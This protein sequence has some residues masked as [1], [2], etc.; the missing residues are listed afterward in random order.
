MKNYI[1]STSS[2]PPLD[3]IL[4][5]STEPLTDLLAITKKCLDNNFVS[6]FLAIIGCVIAFHYEAIMNIQDE[7]PLIL[8][9]SRES[10][11]GIT[12]KIMQK[13]I[14]Q[15]ICDCVVLEFLTQYIIHFLIIIGKSTSLKNALSLFGAHLNN[16][17]APNTPLAAIV[18]QASMTTVP[19][20]KQCTNCH[21]TVDP[22]LSEPQLSD[23]AVVRW[24]VSSTTTT[25]NTST[26][27]TTGSI[28]AATNGICYTYAYTIIMITIM[29]S[30]ASS[31]HMVYKFSFS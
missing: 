10:G 27:T 17:H 31:K 25:T 30:H 24:A 29:R 1:Q 20:G 5:L 12:Y 4:P 13:F 15:C 2:S 3:I 6:S 16:I 28:S 26:T 14:L 22:Q 7:C 8:C 11:T 9:Y 19:L 21:Y 18:S 23:Q